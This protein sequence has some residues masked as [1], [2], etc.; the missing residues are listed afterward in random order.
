MTMRHLRQHNWFMSDIIIL[1]PVGIA[2]LI[3]LHLGQIP[4]S[5]SQDVTF[6]GVSSFVLF[7]YYYV[8]RLL[9]NVE[10]RLVI[11]SRVIGSLFIVSVVLS[12]TLNLE[13]SIHGDFGIFWVLLLICGLLIII[14]SGKA[15]KRF[16]ASGED[17]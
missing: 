1:I 2:T 12:A 11:Q 5:T 17:K 6:L 7:A 15:W 10:P 9:A 4:S 13:K 3:G 14:R 16:T 8:V